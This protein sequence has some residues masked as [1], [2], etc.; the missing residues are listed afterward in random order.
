MPHVK[1]HRNIEKPGTPR[2]LKLDSLQYIRGIAAILVVFYRVTVFLK[3]ISATSWVLAVT[4]VVPAVAVS[5]V[6]G[7][8]DVASYGWLKRVTDRSAGAHGVIAGSFVLIFL[9]AGVLGLR[10]K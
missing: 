2:P 8:L 5:A 10:W 9:A 3:L 1:F 6:L 7:T 4:A